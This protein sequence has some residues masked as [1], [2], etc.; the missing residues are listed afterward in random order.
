[1]EKI[2]DRSHNFILN[3]S[4]KFISCL[5]DYKI[6]YNK[7]NCACDKNVVLFFFLQNRYPIM[8]KCSNIRKK[9]VNRYI[10]RSER[11]I[12][13]YYNL[14]SL[15]INKKIIYIYKMYVYIYV[16]VYIYIYIY[17]YIYVCIYVC[18]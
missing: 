5:I 7:T 3:Y 10:G 16:C 9:S 2:K 1:M 18:I 6:S 12:I 14:I 17:I 13:N 4:F 8:V 15:I 11:L